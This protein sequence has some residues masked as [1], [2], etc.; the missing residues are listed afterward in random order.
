MSVAVYLI[1]VVILGLG[2]AILKVPPLVGFIAAGF[3]LGAADVD[4]KSVV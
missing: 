4:R 1:A 2:A 3:L